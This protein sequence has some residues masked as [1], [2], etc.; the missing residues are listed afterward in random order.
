MFQVRAEKIIYTMSY[1]YIN[2]TLSDL[3]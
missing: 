2:K 1:M 3:R